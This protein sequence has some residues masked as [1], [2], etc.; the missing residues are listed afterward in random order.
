VSE[1]GD[2]AETKA[3]EHAE[4]QELLSDY[5][6]GELEGERKEALEAHLAAD[7]ECAREVERLR[8][9]VSSLKGLAEDAPGGAAAPPPTA[10][11]FL[12]GVQAKI[13]RRT[14]GRFYGEDKLRPPWEVLLV[15]VGLV[16][17]AMW[18]LLQP[19]YLLP[20]H[21]GGMTTVPAGT[22]GGALDERAIDR[23]AGSPG[24]PATGAPATG[25]GAPVRPVP[26][27]TTATPLA[28]DTFVDRAYAVRI[29]ADDKD[30]PAVRG[31][32]IAMIRAAG[33]TRLTIAD[34]A[35][36]APIAFEVPADQ[37]KGLANQLSATYKVTI[38]ATPVSHTAR[39]ATTA[40][41][42]TVE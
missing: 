35:G 23:A 33:D 18:V 38:T 3:M 15:V 42:I 14:H 19:G 21:K 31:A 8:L 25:G 13:R 11:L 30:I 17:A 16:L 29:D 20:E 40:G 36:A 32:I 24:A 27:G 9:L 6:D 1:R 28:I 4:A 5:I 26:A 22:A 37:F 41:T 39:S 12:G 10:E 34:A 7:P 2:V